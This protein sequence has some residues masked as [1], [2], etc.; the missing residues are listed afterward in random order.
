MVSVQICPCFIDDDSLQETR[1]KLYSLL[2][3]CI[4]ADL[5]LKRLAF[6]FMN[7][8]DAEMK[9][10]IIGFAAEYEHR[11]RI[12]SKT[13]FHLEGFC[14]KLLSVYATYLMSF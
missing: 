6:E 1:T 8:V 9:P 3:N 11:M 12:G 10:Q 13:I 2:S 14:A 5:I 4:P 7:S